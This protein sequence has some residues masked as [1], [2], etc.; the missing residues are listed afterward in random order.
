MEKRPSK[1]NTKPTIGACEKIS[2]CF[3]LRSENH[4]NP[5]TNSPSK[6]RFFL[7][8]LVAPN[9]PRPAHQLNIPIIHNHNE[10]S[11]MA[12]PSVSGQSK[13]TVIVISSPRKKKTEK[14][15]HSN[16][17]LLESP[18]GQK[19]NNDHN[20]LKYTN[21]IDHVKTQLGTTS[22]VGTEDSNKE[23]QPLRIPTRRDSLNDRVSNFILRAKKNI[24]MTHLGD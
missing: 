6:T 15:P 8:K 24:K 20:N 14:I 17:T 23:R 5:T 10:A 9:K 21:Y 18:P 19:I 12:E 7:Q 1:S 11:K 2:N 4:P 22:N 16:M 3:S 13:G